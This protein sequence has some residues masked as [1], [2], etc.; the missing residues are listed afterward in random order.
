MFRGARGQP[1]ESDLKPTFEP[2]VPPGE[3]PWSITRQDCTELGITHSPFTIAMAYNDKV[4]WCLQRHL[5]NLKIVVP[6]TGIEVRKSDGSSKKGEKLKE[7]FATV[8]QVR[9][10]D[11]V[12]VYRIVKGKPVPQALIPSQ[13]QLRH[14]GA[15]PADGHCWFVFRGDHIGRYVRPIR[16]VDMM[17]VSGEKKPAWTVVVVERQGPGKP[18]KI[19]DRR[20]TVLNENLI[21]LE[22]ASNWKETDKE[23]LAL[24]EKS[25]SGS[26]KMVIHAV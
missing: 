14:P 16:W 18:D 12:G 13:V 25:R 20:I 15:K 21:I 4:A 22:R 26:A 23:V 5:E 10:D 3:G 8:Q 19:T 24:R 17:M 1:E 6:T 11:K 7:H 2:Y 9:L